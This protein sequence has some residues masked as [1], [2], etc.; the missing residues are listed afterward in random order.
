MFNSLDIA[1]SHSS[2]SDDST[3]LQ[4]KIVQV[5]VAE[6]GLLHDFARECLANNS[7]NIEDAIANF[8]SLHVPHPRTRAQFV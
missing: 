4:A 1:A 6:T 7:W 3:E 2:I 8:R 5:V